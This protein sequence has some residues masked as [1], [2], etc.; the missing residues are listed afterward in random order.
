MPDRRQSRAQRGFARI[1]GFRADRLGGQVIPGMSELEARIDRR[2]DEVRV[3]AAILGEVEEFE[4]AS[5][6]IN[7]RTAPLVPASGLVVTGAGVLAKAT[8][9]ATG[10]A[11]VAMVLA[12]V[13]MCFLAS[14]LFTHAGRR[15]VGVAPTRDDL[16]FARARLIR[17]EG[18]AQIGVVFSGLATLVRLAAILT[19]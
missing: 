15:A 9:A 17:K 2:P 16:A 6:A 4:R 19:L 7:V 10:L 3:E 1:V 13:G 8:D 11:L 12:L 14:A 5:A 18:G